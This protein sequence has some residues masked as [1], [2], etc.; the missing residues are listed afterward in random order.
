MK[1]TL[2]AIAA[3]LLSLVPALTSADT[4]VNAFQY[5]QNNKVEWT[6]EVP[7]LGAI[8][9][10]DYVYPTIGLRYQKVVCS[11]VTNMCY[12]SATAKSAFGFD[13]DLFLKWQQ[14]ATGKKITFV[15]LLK[16][17]G[18]AQ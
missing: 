12:A 8:D 3:F 1:K 18:R 16:A 11:T 7:T 17:I 9:Y 14:E 4:G 13:A 6:F 10:V 5:Y 2:F 15:P